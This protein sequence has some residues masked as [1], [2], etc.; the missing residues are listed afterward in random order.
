MTTPTGTRPLR[1]LVVALPLAAAL[2]LTACGNEGPRATQAPPAASAESVAIRV[3]AF[4]PGTLEVPVGQRV[5]WTNEDRILHTVTSGEAGTKGVPGVSDP[6]PAT[7]DGAFDRELDGAGT[8]FSF[9][10][11]EAG[12][13]PYFCAIHPGM[14]GEVVVT[15]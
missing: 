2:A 4:E 9:T 5:T 15:R 14:V 3:F 7:P 8:S 11:E 13:Y 6:V 12:T 10:F 1:R